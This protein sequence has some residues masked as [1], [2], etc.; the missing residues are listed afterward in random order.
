MER[1]SEKGGGGGEMRGRED[2]ESERRQGVTKHNG[3][4]RGM[5]R[6]CLR[7]FFTPSLSHF[8]MS[9]LPNA[10]DRL[11]LCLG[12]WGMLSHFSLQ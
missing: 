12:R 6:V 9:L 5:R 3:T 1:A 10:L 4:M 8:A 11:P 7:K 2:V